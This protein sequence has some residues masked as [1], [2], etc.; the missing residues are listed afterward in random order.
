[1]GSYSG[2]IF[3]GIPLP[4]KFEANGDFEYD[5][6]YPYET[7]TFKIFAPYDG[8]GEGV[9]YLFIKGTLRN[10]DKGDYLIPLENNNK[11][12]SLLLQFAHKNNFDVDVTKCGW[13]FVRNEY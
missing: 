7:E 12:I 11:Y 9:A 10:Q 13:W 2:V 8:T 5:Y 4:P 1:M 6:Y 3:F